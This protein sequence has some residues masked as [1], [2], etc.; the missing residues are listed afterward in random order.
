[1]VAALII[2]VMMS[3]LVR[4][5]HTHTPPSRH[6]STHSHTATDCTIMPSECSWHYLLYNVKV[7]IICQPQTGSP[8]G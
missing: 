8:A 7:T 1:M 3:G 4:R 2:L 6:Q 5:Q